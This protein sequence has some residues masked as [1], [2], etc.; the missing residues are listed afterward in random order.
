[1][2]S[3]N[4]SYSSENELIRQWEELVNKAK[5]LKNNNKYLEA[6][7]LEKQALTI[8]Q[9]LWTKYK[10]P[11]LLV[12]LNNL[13]FFYR[14]I[15][16]YK[17]GI[18]YVQ[19]ALEICQQS[20]PDDHHIFAQILNALGSLYFSHGKYEEATP[21]IKKALEIRQRLHLGDHTH[22]AISLN[23]LGYVYFNQ[24]KYEE[25][26]F[27][28]KQSLEMQQR[29][30]PD[31][32]PHI[33]V[34][35]NNL[36]LLLRDIGNYKEGIFY[37]QQ[38]LKI[39]QKLY[40]ERFYPDGHPDMA[41]S[42]NALGSLY[43]CQG[44]YE[45]AEPY[46][47]KAL[48]MQRALY[49]NNHPEMAVSLN[50]LALLYS[51]QARYEDAISCHQQVLEIC[52]DLY[53]S[54][55]LMIAMSLNSLGQIY[56]CQGEYEKVEFYLQ[57]SVRMLERL[58]KD[59]HPD[60]A[61]GF[62][63]LGYLYLNQ[64]KYEQAEFYYQQA[65]KMQQK[66]FPDAHPHT[67]KTLNSLGILY[68]NREQYEE[69]ASFLKQA[70]EIQ[71]SLFPNGHIDIV[72]TFNNIAVFYLEFDQ[73]EQAEH[74]LKQSVNMLEKLFPD[75]HPEV[76]TRLNNLGIIYL[77]QK[78]YEKAKYHFQQVFE[79]H[80]KFFPHCHPNTIKSIRGLA[81][82][83]VATGNYKESLGRLQ[84]AIDMENTILSRILAAS[85]EKDRL[86]Y[87]NQIRSTLDLYFSLITKYFE[88]NLEIVQTTLTLV[89]QRK[90]INIAAITA[91]NAAIYSG[92]YPH[93]EIE[94]QKLRSLSNQII[95]LT[96]SSNEDEFGNQQQLSIDII[97]QQ[98][99]K[100]QTEYD[101]LEKFLATQVPEI[102][103]KEEINYQVI[104]AEI[105]KDTALVEFVRF[106]NLD[107]ERKKSAKGHYV[108]FVVSS[109]QPEQIVMVDLGEAEPIDI[110]IEKFRAFLISSGTD[111]NQMSLKN[112]G[113]RT[114]KVKPSIQVKTYNFQ[115]SPAKELT[116][117]LYQPLCNYLSD[118]KNL[119]IAPDSVLS[120]LPFELLPQSENSDIYLIDCYQ[121]IQ[122]ITTARDLLRH[123]RQPL[124]PAGISLVMADPDYDLSASVSNTELNPVSKQTSSNKVTSH[125]D[126]S[127]QISA[128]KNNHQPT[129]LQLSSGIT[130]MEI[131]EI[132]PLERLNATANLGTTIAHRLQVK[133]YLEQEAVEPLVRDSQCPRVL[134]LAT[135]GLYLPKDE[136]IQ[137]AEI[138][139]D[140]FDRW[141]RMKVS[142]PMMRSM[143]A[144]AGAN[145]W[146]TQK[147]LPEKAG[148]GWLFAQD[149]ASLDLWAN[150]MTILLACQTGLGDVTTG[151]GVFGLRSAFACA[152]AKTVIMSLWSV[153]E[154]A[155]VLLMERF[156]DYLDR[157]LNKGAALKQAQNYIRN[158]TIAE[159]RQSDTGMEVLRELTHFDSLTPERELENSPTT[160]PLAHPMFWGA[161]ICQG[162]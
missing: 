113:K 152:G 64:G 149:V 16:N 71:Q 99:T 29:L 56:S 40:P 53:P 94:F 61:V 157:G 1:M 49:P 110:L 95:R 93:L 48:K 7:S 22:L 42:L 2:N 108:A 19:Q 68:S 116:K 101:E 62:S 54:D 125:E 90:A 74:F 6:I 123:K 28:M 97:N 46:H 25:S 148:K 9:Q 35:L 87:L 32:H 122:Y 5:N 153:P 104:A 139:I 158:V 137:E 132:K 78:E 30:H 75:G 135:H 162:K 161:W 17:E 129:T 144:F 145:S 13:G 117:L 80:Q 159:L 141:R 52:Q 82:V 103:L 41:A 140:N 119:I 156:F 66:I 86:L 77:E 150:E 109:Q 31:G 98:V 89:W 128:S 59:D 105:P 14:D 43:C 12:N 118:I 106:Q 11:Y 146:I 127:L 18:F 92:R 151:E 133:P 107:F 83:F 10:Q 38:A 15:G 120:L 34:G 8:A 91:L 39:C 100:A 79:I 115:A 76:A 51:I 36:S 65:L 136:T 160:K 20:Y 84:T 23:D 142:N 102:Q 121:S 154:K 70:L 24:G 50:N 55:H 33:V 126:F 96:T 111:D 58:F 21:Y 155:S 131:D 73:Y 4:D 124:R 60:I 45:D 114:L 88:H 37:V 134:L 27:Y 130:E 81:T 47:H 44:K 138:L 112:I 26:A 147:Q 67:G 85:N 69:G 63:N 57:Q 3:K 143:L 72:N